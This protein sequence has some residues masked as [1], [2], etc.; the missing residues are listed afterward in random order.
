MGERGRG[1][2]IFGSQDSL[3]HFDLAATNERG[4]GWPPFSDR[5]ADDFKPILVTYM[6]RGNEARIR[7]GHHLQNDLC[8]ARLRSAPRLCTL[9]SPRRSAYVPEPLGYLHWRGCMTANLNSV[10]KEM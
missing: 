3:L 9:T 6:S 2:S 5:G 4:R 10:V 7:S 8:L 1:W